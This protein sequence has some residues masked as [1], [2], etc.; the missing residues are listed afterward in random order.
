MNFL[1]K[2]NGSGGRRKIG[3]PHWHEA[4]HSRIT[5]DMS[6]SVKIPTVS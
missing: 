6:D 1:K 3:M 4:G 5:F 2:H